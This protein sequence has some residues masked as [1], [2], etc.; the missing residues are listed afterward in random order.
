MTS[1]LLGIS[2]SGLRASQAALNTTG[3]NISNAAVEGYS[4][5][6]VT[7]ST[8]QSNLVGGSFVGN[9]VSVESIQRIADEFI[10]DQLANDTSLFGDLD[11]YLDNISQLDSLLADASTGLS[12]ALESFFA[13]VQNGADDP[14]SIPARQLI[15]SEAENL[16]DRFNT[17]E[18][19]FDSINEGIDASIRSS[20]AQVN[21]L[22][23][24]IA[25]LNQQIADAV[26]RS[27]GELPNEL[28]DQRDLAIRELA[29]QVDIQTF[30]QGFG[31]INVVV[32]GGQNLVVG[33]DSRELLVQTS[34][35]DPTKLD[36][37]F[38][39]GASLTDV[40][41]L[42][43]GGELGGAVRFQNT[44]LDTAY[45]ELGR[46]ALVLADT[47]NTVHRQ[48]VT[49]NDDF[50]ENFFYDVNGQD[51]S[52]NRVVSNAAN[53]P[54]EDRIIEVTIENTRELLADE[55][56]LDI[57]GGGLFT[58][59]RVSDGEEVSTGL[60]TGAFPQSVSFDGVEVTFQNGTFQ[61]GDQFL[62]QPTRSAPRDFS[63]LLTEASDIAFA[64]PVITEAELGNTGSGEISSGDV[65]SLV[66]ENGDPLP[67]FTESGQ[68]SPPLKIVFTSPTTYDVLD[69]SDPSNLVQLDPPIRNQQYVVGAEEPIFS[70]DPG[71]TQVSTRG[72]LIG[73]PNGS[74]AVTTATLNNLT[75]GIGPNFAVTD[76]SAAADQFSFD[77]TVSNSL[78]G[79][80]DTTVTVNINNP[81]IVDSDTLLAVV[82]AQ[83]SGTDVE[84]YLNEGRLAFR[85]DTPGFG[86]L[87]ISNYAGGTA[88][89][90]NT[91]LGFDVESTAGGAVS[92]TTVDDLD[93][94]SGTGG[95]NN[96]YP[97]EVVSFTRPSGVPG[98]ADITTNVF[99]GLH[100]SAR[101]IA[102]QL[103]NQPGVS[104]TAY[105]ALN[106]SNLQVSLDSPLQI[107]LNGQ[108][109]IQYE[110]DS[111]TG[112]LEI[113]AS[114]PD[115]QLNPHEFNL[116]LAQRIEESSSL[117]EFGIRANAVISE[118]TGESELR[119]VAR[120]GD[121]LNI[122]LTAN[123]GE[124]IDVNDDLN[125]NV[126]LT[127]TGEQTSSQL[128]VGGRLDVRLA[129]GVSLTTFPPNSVLF[130]D[131]T[132]PDFAKSTFLGIQASIG[133]IPDEGDIFSINFNENAASDNRNALALSVLQVQ[134]T[135]D[136]GTSNF[137]DGYASLV[138]IIG[139]ETSSTRINR[140]AAEQVLQ[141]TNTLR[142]SISGVNLDEEAANLLRF[143]QLYSANARVITVANELFDTLLNTIG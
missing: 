94:V 64:S 118:E 38:E 137:S 136:G 65:L 107:S 117:E 44:I 60:L 2:V 109:L 14:T 70:N 71:E 25:N 91:L 7:T 45:N 22:S 98:E 110:T 78:A 128:V 116:Y 135:L 66:D 74:S 55:Y 122:A 87:S 67:L 86:D 4:R 51:V 114:V 112:Q 92:F 34:A 26:G 30:N 84:A 10:N 72:V 105:T 134:G 121:D 19:R 124:S 80:N 5:Q 31:Q 115:P 113:A 119:L 39:N 3:N 50:G 125:E 37:G 96:G 11:I 53:P 35:E 24:N 36:I 27:G 68:L 8:I 140:N 83:L 103:S 6:R 133:G 57:A 75:P 42:L 123:E 82:N 104:A 61:P 48:G 139:I 111:A 28:L 59:T 120:F 43:S 47:F 76:F 126:E 89:Q 56:N 13:S 40:T 132:A 46:V 29:A 102:N 62:I 79:A 127:G 85:L 69:A 81:A 131:T 21:A 73:L 16:A 108:D 54:P 130:G 20:V 77:V 129:D 52:Q 18:S 1:G 100:A 9:G 63:A 41:D 106:I 33:N 95:L 90:A 32:A 101:E 141:Q 49:L 17:L 23:G 88:G 15:L 142:E 12:S 58:I 138:E 93:G 99:T 143:E 97:P